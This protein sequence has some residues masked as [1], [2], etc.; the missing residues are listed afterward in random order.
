[1]KGTLLGCDLTLFSSVLEEEI[2]FALI[3][4]DWINQ[5]YNDDIKSLGDSHM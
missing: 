2:N 1:M 4:T 5:F 3:S